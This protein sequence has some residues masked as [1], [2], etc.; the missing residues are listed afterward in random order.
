MNKFD[1]FMKHKIKAKYYIRYADDFVILSEDKKELEKLIELIRVF[2]QNELKLKLHPNKISIETFSSGVDFLGMVNFPNYKIL[3]TKTKRRM[4]KKIKKGK[5]DLEGGIISQESFNY[6][7]QSYL[8]VLKHC[9]G[10]KIEEK[11]KKA[12]S[13][14]LI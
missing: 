1:Q 7:L 11:L 8:G 6:S 5:N 13:I 10:W 12:I 9:E 2:L 3:R 4:F 14:D